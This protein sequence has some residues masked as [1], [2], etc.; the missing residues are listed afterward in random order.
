MTFRRHPVQWRM[1]TDTL[2]D[3]DWVLLPGTL[4][5]ANVFDGLLGAIGVPPDRRHVIELTRP[6]I[7][8]YAFI[9]DVSEDTVVCGFSLG[10]IVAA[11]WAD[12]IEAARLVFFGVNP[13]ADDPEKTGARFAM[14]ED[15]QNVGGAAALSGR[16]PAFAGA[17]PAAARSAALHMADLAA[18]RIEAQ[19]RLALSRPGALP[20]L[21]Q[22]KCPVF[23]LTGE[24]DDM[25][26]AALGREAA[27]TAPSGQFHLLPDLGHYALLEDAHACAEGL[28]KLESRH[29]ENA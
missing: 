14:M 5:T 27:Q 24:N 28:M 2:R 6:S 25:A 13:L 22:A 19:T 29:A 9:M 20:A 4:C 10:A 1:A 12:R 7:D 17:D 15:V 11:H 23:A 21:A 8:D 16:L 18:P 26:P 3:R